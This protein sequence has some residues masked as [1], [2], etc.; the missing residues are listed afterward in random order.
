MKSTKQLLTLTIITAAL[1]IIASFA[2]M[3]AEET[4]APDWENPEVF[5]INKE[6]PHVPVIPY[7]DKAAAL[8]GEWWNSP[9]V[10]SLNGVWKFH[11]VRIPQQRPANFYKDDYDVSNWNSIS[12]P[13]NWELQGWGIPLYTDEPYPFKPNPPKTPHDHNP[14]GSYR[15][16]FELP[17]KWNGRR[18]FLHFAGVKS[19]MYLWVNGKE[20]GY[21][22][23]SRTPA[24]FDVTQY[25]R[26]GK[27]NVSVEVYRWS[28]GSYL[29]NQDAWRMSGIERDVYLYSVPNVH[30][31]DYFMATGLD[32]KYKDGPF[33]LDIEIVRYNEDD[34]MP[35]TLHVE[36]LE[37][38]GSGKAVLEK[39]VS[40]KYKKAETKDDKKVHL[41]R[42]NGKVDIPKKW[43]AETPHLYPLVL[44]LKDKSGKAVEVL[45]SNT[46]FRKIEI[47]DGRFLVNGVAV[48]IRGVNRCVH[49]Q[50]TGHYVTRESMLQDIKLMKQFNI[51]AVRTSH[52]PNDVY[53]YELCD[54]YGLYVVDEAN[55]ESGGMYFH[56]QKTLLDKPQWA[57]AFLDRTVRM[58]ERDKNFPSI[59][60]WSLGNENIDGP[61][62]ITNYDWI[63]QRDP[64]RPVQS[65]DA[66][67][68]GHTDIYCPMYRTIK[69]IEDYAKEPRKRP[70]IL[71]EYAHA[72][73]NSVGNLQDYWDVIYKYKNLQ[74]GFIWD[75]VDQGVVKTNNQ[76]KKYWA[77]GGDYDPVGVDHTMKNFLINGLVAPDRK[78]HPSTLR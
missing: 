77:Y 62:L 34:K 68:E 71:C 21:S 54:R 5:N 44:T 9:Y 72:M 10:E 74:G 61:H 52:Y 75:W 27:N 11:W 63:K 66:K 13:G 60:T 7:A 50:L 78:V 47:K 65:E 57:Q 56:P 42:F 36:I 6:D 76:G 73:G 15:R 67:L 2:P 26:K 46:G 23:G 4:Q 59:V 20:V 25:V 31:R 30:I 39:P 35:Y 28:D 24:E 43:T 38:D 17:E 33:S 58:V 70:L 53:W 55:I 18:I 49:D 14:V 64:S 45:T 3:Q 69:Q 8:K 29:E 22:Q 16:D 48:Y 51:N 41:I 12:V 40:L 19:A 37:S 1:F 32:E